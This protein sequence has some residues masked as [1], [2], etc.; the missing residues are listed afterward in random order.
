[1]GLKDD[2]MEAKLKGLELSGVKKEDL[3][4]ARK[5]GSAVEVQAE[6]EK[7]AII[8]YLTNSNFTITQLKAPVVLETFKIPD[9]PV[10][11]ALQTLLGD[12]APILDTLKKLASPLGLSSAIDA[13]ESQLKKAVEPLLEAGAKLPG[14][15]MDKDDGKLESTGYV[16]IGED[17]DTQEAFDVSD[18]EGQRDHTEVKLFNDDI[19]EG[20]NAGGGLY[21]VGINEVGY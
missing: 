14:L 8:K 15:D 11:M 21:Q 17:P 13:L 3:D 6:M 10:D 9:Q 16:Y 12:K 7:E 1:M 5:D 19:D 2:L 18:S 20:G 4:N